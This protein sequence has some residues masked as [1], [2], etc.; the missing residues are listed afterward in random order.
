MAETKALYE[1]IGM[2]LKGLLWKNGGPVIGIQLENE[3]AQRGPGKGAAYILALKK[4]ALQS[5]MDVPLY[6]VTG[7]DHAVV[8]QGQVLP[9]YGGYPDAPGETQ[10]AFCPQEV[11]SRRGRR[12]GWPEA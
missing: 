3:Y 5:G 10:R 2:Q 11:G 8:P 1:Q 6:S 4:L 9:V 7:W 12:L